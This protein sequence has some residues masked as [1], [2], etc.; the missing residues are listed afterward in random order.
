MLRRHGLGIVAVLGLVL[1][2]G[3][4]CPPDQQAQFPPAP[5]FPPDHRYT[6]DELIELSVHRSPGL[7][8]VRNEAESLQGLVDQV[9]ALYLPALRYDFSALT[10]S[11][12]LNYKTRALNLVS[13]NVPL[14]GSY[15]FL[16]TLNYAQI[17]W[18]G[19]K[20]TSLLKQ[21]K[22][23]AAIGKF[24]VLAQQD[25]VACEV[26]NFYYLV[27]LSNGIDEVVE[28]TLRRLRVFRQVAEELN[29]RGSLRASRLD[30]LE[31]DLLVNELEQLQVLNK[32]A[33]Q[34]A[35]A[36]LK[37]AIG[38]DR[39]EP[40]VL[41]D[42]NLPPPLGYDEA[43]TVSAAILKGFLGRPELR[44]IDLFAKL[45]GE[46]VKLA[47]ASRMPNVATVDSFTDTQGNHHTILEQVDGLVAS[48][49]V[50]IPIYNPAA[51][52]RLRT[53]LYAEQAS[54]ALQEFVEQLLVLEIE[55]TATEAQRAV[56]TVLQSMRLR[57]I[58]QDHEHAARQ[59]Y[60]RELIPA[61]GVIT[62]IGLN[63]F[64]R[65]QHLTAVFAQHSARAR[66]NRVTANRKNRY[67]W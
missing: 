26:A 28:D 34:Q 62:A 35:Y 61:S 25:C 14:T 44:Q 38:L 47:K 53:A 2:L 24:Q 21:A 60:T 31:A 11:N 20:R 7:D 8:F 36:A 42:V 45:S 58:A 55:V 4:A 37:R 13:V 32:A 65:I 22:M 66:L 46:Q 1:S 52:A 33:R 17:L 54:Q 50:D 49:I 16:N 43:V 12:D 63:A 18:T 56:K 29:R 10:F 27:C 40:L 51:R 9:K 41:R 19:G 3:C 23:L 59:A 30:A 64:A 67:G 6:L 48:L 5:Q 15:N 57:E 39:D